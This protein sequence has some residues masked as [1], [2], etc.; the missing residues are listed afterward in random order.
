MKRI[1]F[2]SEKC[3]ASFGIN[4]FVASEEMINPFLPGASGKGHSSGL[5]EEKSLYS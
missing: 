5:K 2:N 3:L 4:N 1:V